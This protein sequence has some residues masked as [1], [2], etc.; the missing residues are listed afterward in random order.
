[1]DKVV[2]YAATRNLYEATAACANSALQNGGIDRVVILIED[3]SFP[4][5]ADDDRVSWINVSGQPWF[6]MDGPNATKRWTWMVLMKAALSKIFPELD[7]VLYLD[8]D[9]IVLQDI[10]ELWGLD[11]SGY[12]FAAVPQLSDGRHGAFTEGRYYNAGVLFCNLDLLRRHGWDDFLIS[13]I[14]RTDYAFCEQDAINELCGPWIY[15]LPGRWNTCSYTSLD[16][17]QRI[18]HF[19][20]TPYWIH[21][22]L[23]ELYRKYKNRV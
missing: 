22:P 17:E 8:S 10:S 19:A 9:T 21:T 18:M 14:N 3:D 2:V 1:M 13:G 6:R 16:F 4:Y 7:K 23:F 12:Y 5:F 20:A 11:L 15:P